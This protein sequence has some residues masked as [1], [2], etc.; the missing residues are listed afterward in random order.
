MPVRYSSA[1][2][3]LSSSSF[4]SFVLFGRPF[5]RAARSS[6]SSA[7]CRVS[8]TSAT[9]SWSSGKVKTLPRSSGIEWKKNPKKS[10]EEKKKKKGGEGGISALRW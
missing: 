7:S 9:S 3:N 4:R 1:S 8:Q 10:A 5:R 2:R 6:S